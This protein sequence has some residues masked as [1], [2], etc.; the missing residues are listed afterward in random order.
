MFNFDTQLNCFGCI[1]YGWLGWLNLAEAQGC[2]ALWLITSRTLSDV[3]KS[4]NLNCL[5]IRIHLNYIVRMYHLN[6]FSFLV[7]KI[8]WATKWQHQPWLFFSLGIN[9][10]KQVGFPPSTW[11]FRSQSA[12]RKS[13][14]LLV[15]HDHRN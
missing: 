2:R 3:Q 8:S 13:R 11:V 7:N 15:T 5:D 6:C 9:Q 10:L 12:K 14:F 1:N 4:E